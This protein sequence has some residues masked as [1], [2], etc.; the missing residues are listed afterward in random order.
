[1]E[2]LIVHRKVA[3][4]NTSDLLRH[5]A[6][7]CSSSAASVI[8]FNCMEHRVWSVSTLNTDGVY[9]FCVTL[10]INHD[11]LHFKAIHSRCVLS[12][13]KDISLP[14]QTH[15]YIYCTRHLHVSA[16]EIQPSPWCLQ[17][18]NGSIHSCEYFWKIIPWAN[19]SWRRNYAFM[20]HVVFIP[21]CIRPKAQLC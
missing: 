1:V 19:C 15:L 5:Y 4:V 17:E 14:A 13:I 8:E 2:D 10:K 11:Y 7:R 12:T 21:L 9:A 6:K 20:L 18:Q 3:A 16:V